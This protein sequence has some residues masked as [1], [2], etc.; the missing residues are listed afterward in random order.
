MHEDWHII[1]TANGRP[2]T[3][4]AGSPVLFPSAEAA[5]PFITRAGDRVERWTGGFRRPP[6]AADLEG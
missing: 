4:A 5:G 1:V 2:L 6:G 3:G